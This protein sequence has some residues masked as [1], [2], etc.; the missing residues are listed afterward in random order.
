MTLKGGIAKNTVEILNEI[1]P[2]LSAWVPIREGGKDSIVVSFRHPE[3]HNVVRRFL[4]TS[5]GVMLT[6]VMQI[7]SGEMEIVLA[8]RRASKQELEYLDFVNDTPN[9][10]H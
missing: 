9:Q 5:I 4:F 10:I 2:H 8:F 6:W 1:A 7:E 3:V